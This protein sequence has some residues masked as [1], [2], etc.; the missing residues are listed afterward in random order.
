MLNLF[1]AMPEAILT[2]KMIEFL[3]L[4]L[5]TL[6]LKLIYLRMSTTATAM[7]AIHL[8]LLAQSKTC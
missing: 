2:S 8:E 3:N 5:Y 4:K 1:F 6:N 7:N